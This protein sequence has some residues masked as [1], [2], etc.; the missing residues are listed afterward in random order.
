MAGGYDG[1]ITEQ[2]GVSVR[3]GRLIDV[4]VI[5]ILLS[6]MY[7]PGQITE[8][9][10][11]WLE[12]V[13]EYGTFAL[14][15]VLMF[16]T[17]GR[18][19]ADMKLVD[20]KS[21]YAP[22]YVFTAVVCLNSIAFSGDGMGMAMTCLH[23][24]ATVLFALWLCERYE[25]AQL[26]E[27]I[28]K[29]QLVMTICILLFTVLQPGLAFTS[30]EG[31][32]LALTGLVANKNTCAAE[33]SFGVVMA[34]LSI[35]NRRDRHQVI[36]RSTIILFVVDVILLFMCYATGSRI[37]ALVGVLFIFLYR[38]GSWRIPW[39][40]V[41]I[42]ANIGFLIFAL[43]ILPIFKPLLNLLG[44]DVTLTGRTYTWNR[45]IAVMSSS[46]TLTGF[47]YSNFWKNTKSL[48]LFHSGFNQ[49]SFWGSMTA[50][51]HND[52]LELWGNIGLIGIALLFIMLLLAFRGRRRMGQA[53]YLMCSVIMI[54]QTVHGLTER[55]FSVYYYQTL[56][57]F[58]AIGL[59][60]RAWNAGQR[61]L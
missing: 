50:G 11:E 29:A 51:S 56:G 59:A 47:G 25:T 28:C 44:K 61:K 20:L 35:R 3:W 13:Y 38:K 1:T 58:I 34:A 53:E 17:S 7:F 55:S 43:T 42:I 49:D 14:E 57:L 12:T 37:T 60:C 2:Y 41:Y 26:T 21:C 16:F 15:I 23:F 45:M 5:L 24:A 36:P 32:A 40:Y 54:L 31:D 30:E 18:N 33:L 4:A 9:T 10:G 22:V 52:L 19:L 6:S 27:L 46:H 39:G 48:A 8:I